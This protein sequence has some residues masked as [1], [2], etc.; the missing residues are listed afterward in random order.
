MVE[1]VPLMADKLVWDAKLLAE[2]DDPLGLR[3]P[4]MVHDKHD[5]A[6]VPNRRSLTRRRWGVS[7]VWNRARRRLR[8]R[9]RERPRQASTRSAQGAVRRRMRQQP[10]MDL[11]HQVG[12][13]DRLGNV[14]VHAGLGTGRHMLG[15]DVGAERE[16]RRTHAGGGW[17]ARMTRVAVRPSMPGICRSIRIRSKADLAASSI[18]SGPDPASAQS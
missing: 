6:P 4:E 10:A 5:W 13:S 12:G 1:R 14:V 17:A 8:P 9:F 16:D 11:G 18:A 2:P 3:I 7:W 15:Q